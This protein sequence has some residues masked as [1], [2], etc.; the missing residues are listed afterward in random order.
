MIAAGT[1]GLEELLNYDML[2][3]VHGTAMIYCGLL[4]TAQNRRSGCSWRGLQRQRTC[5]SA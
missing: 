2:K 1:A 3:I 4:Q 5:S